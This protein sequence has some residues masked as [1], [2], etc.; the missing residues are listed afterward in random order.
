LGIKKGKKNI[1]CT[2]RR[3]RR[4]INKL[5][6]S[7]IRKIIEYLKFYKGVKEL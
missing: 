4:L 7:K 5:R 3:E 6:K 2:E 1:D